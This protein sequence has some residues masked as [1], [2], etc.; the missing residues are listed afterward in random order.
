MTSGVREKGAIC[1]DKISRLMFTR[2]T[3]G[4]SDSGGTL[5]VVSYYLVFSIFHVPRGIP[6]FT[7]TEHWMYQSLETSVSAV[8]SESDQMISREK[9]IAIDNLFFIML[10]IF[11]VFIR[12]RVA[13]AKRARERVKRSYRE[14]GKLL[15]FKLVCVSQQ[16]GCVEHYGYM[17]VRLIKMFYPYL[18]Y[19][20]VIPT[21]PAV[22]SCPVT[23]L[24]DLKRKEKIKR[25]VGVTFIL[26]YINH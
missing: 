10:I 22:P 18:P 1:R 15:F 24:V 9:S 26:S 6:H 2:L 5:R 17:L 3:T 25:G 13:R 20:L 14:I 11:K 23:G 19:Y 8:P 21:H 7:N 16:A 4:G 12:E